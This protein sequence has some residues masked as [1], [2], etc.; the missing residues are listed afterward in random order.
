MN[1][2]KG[3]RGRNAS[4]LP[5]L[6]GIARDDI[7]DEPVGSH[8]LE[9]GPWT[10][11]GHAGVVVCPHETCQVHELS[12]NSPPE[13]KTKMEEIVQKLLQAPDIELRDVIPV[14]ETG[15]RTSTSSNSVMKAVIAGKEP[16]EPVKKL[17]D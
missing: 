17:A 12:W 2:T 11:A 1:R 16:N 10:D 6:A 9:R 8:Q 14:I 3:L 13:F 15:T 4:I 5:I 7:L